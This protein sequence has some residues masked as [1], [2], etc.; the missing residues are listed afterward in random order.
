MNLI[1]LIRSKEWAWRTLLR[2]DGGALSKHGEVVLADLRTFC[3]GTKSIYSNDALMMARLEGRREVY[4]RVMNF[5]HIDYADQLTLDE[6]Y[7]DE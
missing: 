5:L 4:M 7:T 2:T 6:D 1:K 3:N